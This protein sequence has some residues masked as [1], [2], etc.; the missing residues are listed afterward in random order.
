MVQT[1]RKATLP[2]PAEVIDRLRPAA[3]QALAMT[4]REPRPTGFPLLFTAQGLLI[5]PAVAFLHDHFVRQAHTAD[6]LRTYAEILYDWFETL[7]QNNIRWDDADA[8]DL[9]AYRNRMLAQPSAHTGRPYRI[10]TINH[11]VRGVLRFYSWAVRTH[12]L[13]ASTLVDTPLNFGVA[14]PPRSVRTYAAQSAEQSL[15]ILRQFESLPRPLTSEQACE[16]LATLPSPYDLMARWQLFTGLRISELLSLRVQDVMKCSSS[17]ASLH[18][19]EVTRKGRKPG[20]V[21]APTSLLD[22]TAAYL[23]GLRQA[24]L[25]RAR[26]RGRFAETAALF[27]NSRGSP[28]GKNAYQRVINRTGQACG[29]RAT[30]HLLRATFAC[31]LLARLQRLAS[32]GVAI[33]PLMIV[34]V[35]LG[36]EHIETTDRYLRAIA[37]EAF[38]FKQVLETLLSGAR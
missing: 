5:E 19:I 32:E 14:R 11:R 7:E 27:V 30:T 1:I 17:S 2:T 29:F 9:V 33:N 16:L 24:W 31:M 10:S 25:L 18:T 4:L 15:F 36:H 22:E 13:P 38:A 23:S 8:V 12:W 6:T 20:Y 26:R 35:L 3:T 34:K 37:V 28:V 21:L